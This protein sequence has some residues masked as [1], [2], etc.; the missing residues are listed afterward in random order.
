MTALRGNYRVTLTLLAAA[1]VTYSLLQSLVVP[2]L[3][4]I[5]R[6]LHASTAAAAWVFSALFLSASIATPIAGRLGDMF[7]KQRTLVVILAIFAVGLACSALADSIEVMIAGRAIQGV[8]GAIFPLAF[9]IIRDEAPPERVAQGIGWISALLGIGAAFGIILAGPITQHL[10]Y[11]WLF[12]FPLMAVAVVIVGT[13]ALVPESP[14]R[15]RGRVDWAG[16]VLLAAWLVPFLVGVTEGPIWGWSSGRV[17]GLF[18][19]AAGMLALWITVERRTRDALVDMKMMRRRPVF[20]TNL[21]A[22]LFGFGTVG[23]LL[24]VPA[25]VQQPESGGFGFSA[26]VTEAGV[27]M[28]PLTL[29]M[30]VAGPIA[31]RLSGS[32]GSRV[33]LITGSIASAAAFVF[34]T[35]AHDAAWQIYVGTGLMGVGLGFSFASLAN[36]IVESVPASQTGVAT[37]M[38]TIVRTLGSAV[39]GQVC[40]A[41][42]A[43]AATASGA[44]TERGFTIAFGAC[45][46]S[47]I[48]ALLAALAVPKPAGALIEAV[49]EAA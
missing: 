14:I 29:A 17:V 33:A 6:D 21:A 34:L 42:L 37:G 44:S 46:V 20:T 10:S 3:L 2:S 5:Q 19:L 49:P 36:L 30:L 11:H 48:L 47:L 31:G 43:G 12:W 32:V 13:I 4:T 39:G 40:A 26:S 22:F 1:A 18:A 38:N 41:I 35:L 25:F 24:L 27:F 16:A 8:G 15:A 9:G 28:L 23:T 45:A 7:G